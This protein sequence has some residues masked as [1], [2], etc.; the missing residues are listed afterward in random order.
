GPAPCATPSSP[1]S[2]GPSSPRCRPSVASPGAA[3]LGPGPNPLDRPPLRA[4][5]RHAVGV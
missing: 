4:Q 1:T 5:E 2:S 3:A